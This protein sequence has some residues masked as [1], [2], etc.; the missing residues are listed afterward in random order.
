METFEKQLNDLQDKAINVVR[1][2][3]KSKGVSSKHNNEKCLRISNPEYMRNLDGHRYLM[4]INSDSLVDNEG[5]NYNYNVL[6]IED[7]LSVI[8]YLIIKYKK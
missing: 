2:I 3:I 6:S 4:E 5:Y 7:L 8:D 1:D